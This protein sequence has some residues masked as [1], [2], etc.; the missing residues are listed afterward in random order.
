MSQLS[1][2][3][4]KAENQ[5]QFPNNNNGAITP[6][7]LRAFN[8]DLIDST[9][10]QTVFTNFSGSVA[11]QFQNITFD[12][13][14][15]LTTQSFNQYTQSNDTKWNDLSS[16]TASITA[17]VNELLLLS[18]SLSGGYVTEGEL[19]AATA[20][21][22]N[23]INTLS[24]VTGSYAT[25][26]SNTFNGNQRILGDLFVTSSNQIGFRTSG[27]LI[28]APSITIGGAVNADNDVDINA[29][30]VNINLVSGD[31]KLFNTLAF[32]GMQIEGPDPAI[33]LRDTT[34]PNNPAIFLT[35]RNQRLEIVDTNGTIATLNT[36]SVNIPSASFT[37]S[38]EEGYVWVGGVGNKSI[39]VQTSSFGGGG[40]T[41][42]GSLLTTA[43]LFNGVNLRFTK[44]DGNTFDVEGFVNTG[45]SQI[46]GTMT[47]DGDVNAQIRY[48]M[49]GSQY[50]GIQKQVGANNL[51][52]IDNTNDKLL[53]LNVDT[54]QFS[55]SGGFSAGLQEGYAWVGDSTNRAV[56]VQTSSFAGGGGGGTTYEN[57]TLNPYS[58][59]LI[60]AANGTV[61]SS[62][63]FITA[64]EN[65]QVNLVWGN[66]NLNGAI[67]VSGSS[68]IFAL[69]PAAVAGRVNYIGGS[70]NLFITTQT[71]TNT[72]PLPTIT[73]SVITAGGRLPEMNSNIMG[74]GSVWAITPSNNSNTHQ[75]NNNRIIGGTVI[76]NT[77]GNV[78]TVGAAQ[79]GIV[80]FIGNDVL[81]L[82]NVN[83]NSPSRSIAEINAG[84]TG[85]ARLFFNNNRVGAPF[86]YNGPVSMSGAVTHNFGGNDIGGVTTI[87]A[88]SQS[89]GLAFSGNT[90]RSLFTYNDTASFAPTLGSAPS[91]GSN[92][93]LGVL[94]VSTEN[95]SSFNLNGNL[96]GGNV[97]VFNQLNASGVTMAGQRNVSLSG[98]I[99]SGI[100]RID[101]SGSMG[102]VP[103][104]RSMSGNLIL[105]QFNSA[106][107]SGDGNSRNIIS[108]AVIGAGLNV[109]G[110]SGNPAAGIFQN[111]G[112]AFFGRWNAEDGNKA[113]TA[114][115]IFAVGTGVSGSTGIVRKTG[116][117]IDSGSNTFVEG[118]LNVSGSTS[119]SGSLTIQSGSGDLF[120]HGNKQFNVGEFTSLVTQSG[121]A[122]VSQSVNLDVT[123]ISQG[124]SV[125]SNSQITLANSGTYSITFSAQVLASGGQDT[126]WMWL[127][128]NGVNVSNSA[129]KLIAKNGEESVM[130]V[131]YIVEADANDYYE[132]VYQ[133]LSGNARLLY[134][135]AS[136][137]IPAIPSIILSVKQCR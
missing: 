131:E 104:G 30:D 38:L 89:R 16:F 60:L 130:T 95:S 67:F 62:Y 26:G 124:V 58:G 28:T 77:L 23:Q 86:N 32:R 4:L 12:T 102:A 39:A 73:S 50:V 5:L 14:S 128:K 29:N 97:T 35:N 87:N 115:T 94:T 119:L 17:S 49:S 48:Q 105:G 125:Q 2:Q 137:N 70:S 41:D 134:E 51:V 91:I 65:G 121:S 133:N 18:A 98:N 21:L 135:A 117:L 72:N 53:T 85:S 107:L 99:I 123:N 79:A 71:G 127:K 22:I 114:E 33:G 93:S 63:D 66:R 113:S 57:P 101:I 136:G 108:T 96:L 1:K 31:L 36:A 64:S 90:I 74:V 88:Q 20:S 54:R 106:S 52:W 75:Y 92:I 13:S 103:L 25:T 129:T 43:S 76:L 120:V 6:A 69:S 81:S 110:T 47:F 8:V 42:T 55:V 56:A 118:T 61:S 84:A 9:V 46:F 132:I 24:G 80:N 11:S 15:L 44:G 7:N 45:S 116:F 40:S 27:G 111:I 100:T 37:A 78:A 19:Q 122:G 68:N 3:D 126:F 112:S 34:A 59:S 109:F 82:S 10:N 83:L